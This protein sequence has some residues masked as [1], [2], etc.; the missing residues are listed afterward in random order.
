MYHLFVPVKPWCTKQ[1]IILLYRIMKKKCLH[2]IIWSHNT[3]SISLSLSPFSWRNTSTISFSGNVQRLLRAVSCQQLACTHTHIEGHF[4]NPIH[5]TSCL[6]AWLT[7]WSYKQAYAVSFSLRRA[8][9]WTVWSLLTVCPLYN[10]QAVSR[11]HLPH[12]TSS[13]ILDFRR[14]VHSCILH[15]RGQTPPQ[16][17]GGPRAGGTHSPPAACL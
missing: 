12:H 8:I 9:F 11:S 15:S 14:C 7:I 1:V 10:V 6:S 5:T 4:L 3:F 2:T 17:A 16:W 13:D